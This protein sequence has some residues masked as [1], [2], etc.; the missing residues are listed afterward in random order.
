MTTAGD[1]DA[2]DI[3]TLPDVLDL[4]DMRSFASLAELCENAGLF[5]AV[6]SD[7][8]FGGQ[9]LT[10]AA[11]SAFGRLLKRFDGRVVGPGI[12]FVIEGA[13]RNRVYG[14]RAA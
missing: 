4:G 8:D 9:S 5:E 7:K 3:A 2:A 13:G 1:T 10:P 11:R 14:L 12:R 6:T